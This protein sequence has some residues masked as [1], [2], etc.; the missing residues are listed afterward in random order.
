MNAF[1]V[2]VKGIVRRDGRILLLFNERE[3]ELPGGK[4]EAGETPEECVSREVREE[5]G[6]DVGVSHI[7]DAWVYTITSARS[8]VIITYCCDSSP[9]QGTMLSDEHKNLG[10]FTAAEVERLNMPEGYKR[11]IRS[12]T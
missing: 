4:L 5:V 7:V 10:W 1:P 12:V 2:S 11:S 8:V 6:L 9:G 3:W